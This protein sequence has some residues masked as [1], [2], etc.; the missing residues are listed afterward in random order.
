MRAEYGSDIA[1]D[2]LAELGIEYAAFNPGASF[3]G[4]HDSL[5]N[6]A[7]ERIEIIECGH[8]EISVAIAHGYAKAAGKPM[9]AVV[10]DIVGLQHA[11]MA[12]YNAWCDRAPVLVLG[13]TGPADASR[14]R[15]WIDWIHTAN[16]QATQV[17]DYTKWDDQPASLQALPESLLRAYRLATC[18]PTGPV[19]VCLD[20]D[21]QE[22]RVPEGFRPT[23]AA[24]PAPSRL[25]PE[26]AAVARL[27]EWLTDAVFPVVVADRVGRHETALRK[28]VE[29]AELLAI[30]VLDQERTY[31][32]AA[33]NFPTRHELNLSGAIDETLAGADLVIGMDAKDLFGALRAGDSGPDAVPRTRQGTRV[34][35]VGVDHLAAR[36]WSGDYQQLAPADMH[37]A[38]EAEPLLDAIIPGVRTALERDGRLRELVAKRR[39]KVAEASAAMRARWRDQADAATGKEGR[40]AR[41]QV[42]RVLDDL[43]SDRDRVV[44]NGTLGNWV[45]RLWNLEHAYQYCGESGGAGL[46]Y[47]I[48]AAI[49]VALA[50]RGTDRLVIDLQSDGDAFTTVNALWTAA[51]HRIPVLFVMDNDRSYY[52][53]VQHAERVARAR[54]RP[55]ERKTVGLTIDDPP[56]DFAGIARA[57]G[58]HGEGPV[59]DP[60]TLK[61]SLSRALEVVAAGRPA[62]VDVLTVPE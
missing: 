28:L 25:A 8:E 19:Y 1:V 22:Q 46:G 15:P 21:L 29:L 30:P 4:L 55:V 53:S 26:P 45:H 3:R 16:V 44:A 50:H 40:M 38:C 34:A 49:G 12:I 2:V 17:R 20:V 13:A 39:R 7:P 41:P 48:G 42:A 47:G 27:L 10:H 24:S 57:S 11:S 35:Q 43:T 36:G 6:Y 54:G 23:V 62:L 60:E 52:N 33:L 32:K 59:G 56:I 51:H 58:M 37:V 14:R 61:A 18:A 9:A 5:V 31:N